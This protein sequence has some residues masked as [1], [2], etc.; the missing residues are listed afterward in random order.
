MMQWT[1]AAAVWI[2]GCLA[3][4]SEA[5]DFTF[6]PAPAA[7]DAVAVP[8]GASFERTT[9]FGFEPV[10]T[11]FNNMAGC[12]RPAD[13]ISQADTASRFSIALAEGTWRVD[14]RFAKAPKG[15]VG[16]EA[17]RFYYLPR[18]PGQK[19]SRTLSFVV[20]VRSPELPAPPPN[21]P[22]GTAVRLNPRECGSYSWDGKL[23]IV[24]N[25]D[26]RPT[27]LDVTP[28]EVPRLFLLG[29][30]TVTDQPVA[31]YAGWGQMLP[32]LFGPGIAVANHAESGETLKSFLAELRLDKILSQARG[33]DWAMIQFSHNDEKEM[34]PQTHAPAGSTF[35][36]YLKLYI[37]ELRRRGVTPVLVTPVER[38]RFGADG[39]IAASHGAYP[40]AI[41][42]VAASENVPLIDLTALSKTLFEAMGPQRARDAFAGHGADATHQ[43]AYGA[44]E[45]ARAIAAELRRQSLP[46]AEFLKPDLPSFNPST[47]D[48]PETVTP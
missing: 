29:D 31:P 46:L 44:F 11:V 16:A 12:S 18:A 32:L 38:M 37:A 47:P 24:F 43:S 2:A 40:E 41:R 14:M 36:L 42:A 3:M 33:G 34:W 1:S 39:R 10:G 27:R 48:P 15:A 7:P 26:T 23:T 45:L 13:P 4:P 9:G 22:G 8:A 30:S 20:D 5:A 25:G 19:R 21:A 28:V 6:K 17:R 35:P